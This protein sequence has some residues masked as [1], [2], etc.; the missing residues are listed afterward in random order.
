MGSTD[1]AIRMPEIGRSVVHEEGLALLTQYI[2]E[3]Q[4]EDLGAVIHKNMPLLGE[5]F[6]P[7]YL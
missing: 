3:L 2:K 7:N 6:G 4:A 1:P 5:M